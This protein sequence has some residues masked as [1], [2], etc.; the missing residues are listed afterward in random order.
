MG[1]RKH[2]RRADKLAGVIN[3]A[4]DALIGLGVPKYSSLKSKH[5]Y[6]DHAE[7]SLLIL[8][9]YLGVSYARLCDNLYSLKSVMRASGI[10]RIPHPST[11]RKF[12]NRVH[13]NILN[14]VLRVMSLMVNGNGMT[15]A[16]DATG[17][18][19]SNA[20][21]HF[22]KRLK[23]MGSYVSNVRDYVKTTLAVDTETLM[24]LACKTSISNVHDVKHIPEILDKLAH[25]KFD[26][27]HV[28][29]DRGYDSENVHES[30]RARLGADTVIPT[31]NNTEM[32]KH[33][34]RKS[35]HGRYRKQMSRSFP[36]E[37]YRRR[38]LV[39]TVNSMIKRNMGDTVY[40][41]NDNSRNVEVLCRCIAHNIMRMSVLDHGVK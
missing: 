24:V 34:I 14:D 27:K 13:N 12:A 36:A 19:C 6:S 39:E 21:R 16:V 32:T 18:S 3:T 23:E 1:C 31:R 20:S 37:I 7:I 4:M 17:F 29:A 15:V 35:P 28:L 11:L 8:R 41:H 33:G 38:C 40:G 26:V 2:A 5:T 25:D 30:I 9:Q 10:G 22:V